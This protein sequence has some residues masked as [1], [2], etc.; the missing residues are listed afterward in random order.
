MTMAKAWFW[1]DDVPRARAW[2]D[3][4]REV[5]ADN[6]LLFGLEAQLLL[7][8]GR[9]DRLRAMAAARLRTLDSG[10]ARGAGARIYR[11]WA[12]IAAVMTHDYDAA[13]ERLES[14]LGEGDIINHTPEDVESL[15]FL[16]VAYRRAARDEDAQRVLARAERIVDQ[17]AL[18]GFAA[19]FMD[20]LRAFVSGA[21]RRDDAAARHLRAAAQAGWAK[22]GQ[23]LRHPAMD[24][25]LR[26]GE[27]AEL[28]GRLGTRVASQHQRAIVLAA[29]DGYPVRVA[30]SRRNH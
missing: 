13:I 14:A 18:E 21:G 28:L 20:V 26:R 27:T 29:G 2:L 19:P 16:A 30:S 22:P 10:A 12:G 8:E 3:R 23:V 11:T 9:H 5:G 7:A 4:A 24:Q 1:L 15:T 6:M 17:A 25:L